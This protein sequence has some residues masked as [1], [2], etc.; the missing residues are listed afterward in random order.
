MNNQSI[1]LVAPVNWG[2]GHAARCIPIIRELLEVGHQ[3]IIGSDGAALQLLGKEFPN[4]K[5]VVLPPYEIEYA[6][7]GDS[8]KKSMLKQSP[9][10]LRAIRKEHRVLNKLITQYNIT[11]IISDNRLG[12][13]TKRVPTV[14]ITHQ[15]DVLSGCLLYTSPS[16]RD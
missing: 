14:Y 1:I 16:P 5:L 3:V 13:Y 4:L 15:L 10:I 12:L 11:G 2:L 9:R 6:S 7:E 8:F